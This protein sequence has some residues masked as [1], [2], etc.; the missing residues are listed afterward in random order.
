MEKKKEYQS[1]LGMAGLVLFGIFLV[2]LLF[3]EKMGLFWGGIGLLGGILLVVYLILHSQDLKNILQG[4]AIL[5][6]TN[7]VV[8][9]LAVLGVLIFLGVILTRH[10]WSY[11]TTKVKFYTLSEQTKQT[12]KKLP[13]KV[14]FT[15]FFKKGLIQEM[16]VKDLLKEYKKIAPEKVELEFVDPDQNISLAKRYNINAYNTTVLECGANRKDITE[17]EVFVYSAQGYN[18]GQQPK[19]EFNGEQAFTSALQNVIGQEKKTICFMEGHGE[20]SIAS[21]NTER[22]GISQLKVQLEKENYTV[23]SFNVL[24]EGEIPADCSVLAVAGPKGALGEKEVQLIDQYLNNSGRAIFLLEPLADSGLSKA[25]GDW[26]IKIDDDFVLDPAS[27][28]FFDAAS[29]IPAYVDH[30]IT[31]L[32][33]KE[34]AAAVFSSARSVRE[35]E[36]KKEGAVVRTI[37]ETSR[38]GWGETN[39][40]TKESK[41]DSASDIAGPL[42]L[43][44]AA[45][46][47]IPRSTTTPEMPKEARLVIFGDSDFVSNKMISIRGNIDL[48]LNSVKW[49]IGQK[50]GITIRP[51]SPDIRTVYLSKLQA[52]VVFYVSIF[53]IPLGILLVGGIVFWRRRSL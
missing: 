23:K 43:A 4:R 15:T 41:Y 7:A 1:W 49:L 19:T 48:F 46:W 39:L 44:V 50:E 8:L 5:L 52:K 14:K 36:K 27:C 33:R 20:R 32:L 35:G 25:A 9:S 28:Y 38:Q 12:L 53:L 16:Q 26:G 18:Y 29:P 34:G 2:S 6:G 21:A 22:E 3:V 47:E 37:L 45:Q 51:K 10:P 24:I 31:S 11:D 40:T 17:R 30:E 13:E 42:S